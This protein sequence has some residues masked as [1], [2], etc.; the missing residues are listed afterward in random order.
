MKKHRTNYHSLH[1][2]ACAVTSKNLFTILIIPLGF[3]RDLI[4][5]DNAEDL[6]SETIG[7]PGVLD[8]SEFKAL[9]AE[10]GVVVGVDGPA[11]AFDDHKICATFPYNRRQ[12]FV[13]TTINR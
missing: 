2:R 11:H 4:F 3:I 12:D 1:F 10:H 5:E 8:D 9:A 6:A 7:Q 13:Q